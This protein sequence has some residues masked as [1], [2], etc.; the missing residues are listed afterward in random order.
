MPIYQH[1]GH[2]LYRFYFLADTNIFI[3]TNRKIRAVSLC[4]A[5]NLHQKLFTSEQ[6]PAPSLA[7]Y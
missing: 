7:K 4:K 3:S 2:I 5:I 1:C 6:K